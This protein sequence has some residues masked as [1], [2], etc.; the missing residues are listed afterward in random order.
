[1]KKWTILGVPMLLALAWLALACAPSEPSPP[2]TP[3]TP[4]TPTQPTTPAAPS[5][6]TL[7]LG[8]KLYDN[9]IKTAQVETPEGNSPLWASQTTNTRTGRDTWRCKEC[10]GWDYKGK[11]GAYSK[12]S[13][14]TGFPG[15]SAAAATKT[16]ADLAGALKGSTNPNHDFSAYLNDGQISALAAF[17][18]VGAVID[19]TQYIDY[20][21]K[22][23]KSADAAKGKQ[24]YDSNCVACHGADGKMLNFGSTEDPEYLGTIALDNPWEFIH[25]VRFGQPGTGMPSGV[26]QQWSIQDI[27]DILAHSQTL[28]K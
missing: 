18:K 14:F 8:G 13:H 3:T 12:G 27:I 6:A 7:A 4:T 20:T 21:T 26:E 5:P 15:V 2:T 11:D 24:L 22:A 19:E 23:P 28:P 25:K 17:L 1:M 9:W 10:H 16:E